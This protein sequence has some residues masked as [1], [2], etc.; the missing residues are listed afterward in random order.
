MKVVNCALLSSIK[1]VNINHLLPRAQLPPR[2][3]LDVS[4][5]D[6]EK[7]ALHSASSVSLLQCFSTRGSAHQGTLGEVCRHFWLSHLG[8]KGASGIWW[9]EAR[10][11]SRH[12]R[13]HSGAPTERLAR[14][15]ASVALPSEALLSA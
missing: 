8:G 13:M 3:S 11:A 2:A 5:P 15:T 9:V 12:R 6:K 10:D 14:P 1:S 7:L 4:C